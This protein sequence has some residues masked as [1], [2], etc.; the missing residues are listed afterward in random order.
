MP[1]GAGVG[2]GAGGSG[3]GAGLY[4]G[5]IS[6][7]YDCTAQHI[8]QHVS[9]YKSTVTHTHTLIKQIVVTV[10]ICMIRSQR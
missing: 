7:I 1:A 8:T 2:P 5:N 3:P 10:F 4:P 9:L 6:A